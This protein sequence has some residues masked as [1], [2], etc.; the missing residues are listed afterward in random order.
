MRRVSTIVTALV[1]AAALL[2]LSPSARADSILWSLAG[3][4]AAS[5]GTTFSGTFE[6]DSLTGAITSSS[7]VGSG[8]LYQTGDGIYDVLGPITDR[9][10]IVADHPWPGND[11]LYL[12]FANPLTAAGAALGT[13]Q[14]VFVPGHNYFYDEGSYWTNG[15]GDALGLAESGSANPVPE[16][17]SLV[18]LGVGGLAAAIRRRHGAMRA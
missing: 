3:V 9:S 11:N 18:L 4:T 15:Y 14:V 1:F 6:T 7:I 5:G 2:F 12:V 16:P 17:A 13:N 10:F 8:G